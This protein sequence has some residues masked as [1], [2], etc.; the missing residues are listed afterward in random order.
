M[1]LEEQNHIQGKALSW[2]YGHLSCSLDYPTNTLK[3]T[4][5]L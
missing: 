1:N 2:R 3:V 5:P 4:S